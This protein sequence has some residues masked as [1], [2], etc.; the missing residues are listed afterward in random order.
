MYQNLN[1]VV[2]EAEDKL[3]W[4]FKWVGRNWI[5]ING[6]EIIDYRYKK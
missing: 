4:H 6:V 3:M 2:K 1:C 5:K